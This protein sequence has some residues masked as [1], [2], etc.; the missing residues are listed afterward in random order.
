MNLYHLRYFAVLAH[1]EHYTRAAAELNITQPSL[2]HAINALEEE[3]GVELFEHTG[4]NVT[5]SKYGQLFLHDVEHALSV[6]DRGVERLRRAHE[7]QDVVELGFLRGMGVRMVPRVVTAFQKTPQGKK[8]EFRFAS[9]NTQGLLEQLAAR[10]FD[11]V[12]CSMVP[13]AG[14]FEFFPISHYPLR[15]VVSSQHPL[16]RFDQISLADTVRYPHILFSK[17]AGIRAEIDRLYAHLPQMPA[18]AYEIQEDQDIAGLVAHNFGVAVLP[19]MKL[20]D[21]LPVKSIPLKEDVQRYIY[22]ALPRARTLSPAAAAFRD[23]VL[24]EAADGLQED[25]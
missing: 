3:L 16:A 25:L 13:D 1:L 15:L 19:P 24:A 7:G 11:L 21:T 5:L 20:L 17:T 18:I 22:L 14:A 23:F 6:L 8:V 9:D 2:T 10:K 4:R 12:F